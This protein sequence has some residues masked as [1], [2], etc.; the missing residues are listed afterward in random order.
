MRE[1]IMPQARLVAS[2]AETMS[3][4]MWASD[5]LG[6]CAQMRQ[7]IEEIERI[8]RKREPGER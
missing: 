3:D 2:L 8:A 4:N 6:R 1:N 7:A 5:I